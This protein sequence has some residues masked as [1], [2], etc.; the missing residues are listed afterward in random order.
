[1]YVEDL[2]E[3]RSILISQAPNHNSFDL[4]KMRHVGKLCRLVRRPG[5]TS[6]RIKGSDRTSGFAD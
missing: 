3:S 6:C 2:A 4:L 1:M 5:V